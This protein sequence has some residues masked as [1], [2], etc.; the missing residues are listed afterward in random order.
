MKKQKEIVVQIFVFWYFFFFF[1]FNVFFILFQLVSLH[2][3]QTKA[4][5]VKSETDFYGI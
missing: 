3:K 5:V 4:E 2:G 1:L